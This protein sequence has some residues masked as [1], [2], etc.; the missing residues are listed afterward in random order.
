MR[1]HPDPRYDPKSPRDSYCGPRFYYRLRGVDFEAHLQALPDSWRVT[2]DFPEL[3]KDVENLLLI[4]PGEA[5]PK[6]LVRKPGRPPVAQWR[7]GSTLYMAS[8]TEIRF[9]PGS[10]W[11]EINHPPRPAPFGA[12]PQPHHSDQLA[13]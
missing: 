11:E 7:M 12:K 10:R 4:V 8:L 3:V 9:K 13:A 6:F 5:W 2:S 1:C